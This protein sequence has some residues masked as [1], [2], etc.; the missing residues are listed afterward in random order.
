MATTKLSGSPAKCQPRRGTCRLGGQEIDPARRTNAS[1]RATRLNA[2]ERMTFVSDGAVEARNAARELYGYD[3][4]RALSTQPAA[5]TDATAQAFG[6][7]DD[8]TVITI[9]RAKDL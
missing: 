1:Q 5:Q 4:T 8:I 6:Q 7:D 9:Q 3:R 2:G